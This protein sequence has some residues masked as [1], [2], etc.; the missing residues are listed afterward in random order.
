[1]KFIDLH[2]HTTASDGMLGPKQIVD[3]VLEKNL[4][5][6]AVT[7]HDSINNVEEVMKIGKEKGIEVVSGVEITV[8]D[9]E[10][11]FDDVH[12][13]GLFIDIH[14]NEINDLLNSS[15][16][17]R[18]KQKKETI[19]RLQELGYNVTY[20]ETQEF[21]TGEPGRPH[22]ANVLMKN[23]P[24]EFPEMDDT[25]KKLLAKGRPGFVDRTVK[26]KM[27][28]AIDAIKAAGGIAIL[29]HPGVYEN[30]D[31]DEMIKMFVKLGGQGLETYYPYDRFKKHKGISKQELKEL[32]SYYQKKCE[33]FG[34]VESGGSDYHGTEKVEL[35]EA[36][37]PYSVLER[38]KE[39]KRKH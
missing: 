9:D 39:F 6:M 22:I 2:M 12:V 4:A 30:V 25:F 18:L 21:V 29:C 34:L 11:G 27:K 13:L 37:V 36:E 35:G 7:D 5:A 20:E 23:H 16:D 14:N 28:S 10:Y 26:T 17:A 33:E 31:I 19:R 32:I 3:A 24:D 15:K 8:D 38:L 1:M